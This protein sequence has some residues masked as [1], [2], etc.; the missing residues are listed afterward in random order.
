MFPS[1]DTVGW[2]DVIEFEDINLSTGSGS[3]QIPRNWD[4]TWKFA[5]GVHYRPAEKWLLQLGFVY[6]T[7]P[8]DPRI[9]RLFMWRI[10]GNRLRKNVGPLP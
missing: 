1:L 6:D 5:A 2:E 8:V 9:C 3:R 4:D 10:I 7:S